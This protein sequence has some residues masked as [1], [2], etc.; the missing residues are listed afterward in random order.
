MLYRHNNTEWQD[1]QRATTSIHCEPLRIYWYTPIK[2]L[3]SGVDVCLYIQKQTPPRITYL[4]A[5]TA[6]EGTTP[7]C[8]IRWTQVKPKKR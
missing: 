5:S 1:F 4:Q 8:Y 2:I 7:A 3:V 6:E